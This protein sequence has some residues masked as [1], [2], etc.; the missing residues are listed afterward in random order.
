MNVGTLT[1]SLTA[2]TASL[3]KAGAQVKLF[4]K[5]VIASTQRI[6]ASIASIGMGFAAL[7]IPIAA[8][9]GGSVK[10]FSEFEFSLAK[11]EGL[12][13]IAHE[14]TMKWGAE[15][16]KLSKTIGRSANDLGNALYFVASAGIRGATT[17]EIVKKS[18]QAAAAGMGDTQ[19]IANLLTSVMNAYGET[20]L[21]AAKAMDILVLHLERKNIIVPRGT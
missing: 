6:N 11:V 4:E 19:V 14:Q 15:V 12:V 3:A 21:S 7:T 18:A 1:I 20:T 9:A 16:L 8:L 10:M 5:G 2:R 17:M 13:G